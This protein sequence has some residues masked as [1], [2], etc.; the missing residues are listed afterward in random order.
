M[1]KFI[2]PDFPRAEIIA[3]LRQAMGFGE[4]TRT[5]DKATFVSFADQLEDVATDDRGVPWDV[6]VRRTRT[7]SATV[8]VPC[9][10]EWV[11]AADSRGS[12]GTINAT[13]IKLT[14]LDPDYQ[15]VRGFEYVVIGGDKYLHRETEPPIALGSIDVWIVHVAAEDE[16]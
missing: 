6:N 7:P 3:G 15:K 1:A 2:P 4:R 9:A 13:R 10:V 14:L 11:D 8:Q 16:S 12:Y 5:A